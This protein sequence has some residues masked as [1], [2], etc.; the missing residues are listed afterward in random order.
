MDLSNVVQFII[1]L[2]TP[3]ALNWIVSN[4]LDN[5]PQ[6][7]ALSPS[8]KSGLILVLSLVLS[9]GSY[10][11]IKTVPSSAFDTIQPIFLIIYGAVTAWL[12]GQIQHAR[13]EMEIKRGRHAMI[14]AHR[15]QK[16]VS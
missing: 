2:G 9:L 1:Y 10:A 3:A 8:T 6:W 16:H 4:F 15:A 5:L 14:S 7:V 12:S 13:F 11:V